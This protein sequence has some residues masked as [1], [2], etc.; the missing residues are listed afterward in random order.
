MPESGRVI[1]TNTT[2]LIA[3]AI[4]TGNLNI[5]R[6]L[7]DR[8]VV[9]RE[10]CDEL[11]AAGISAPGVDAF[12]KATWLE[13]REELIELPVY[14]RNTLDRGEAAVIQTATSERIEKVCIDETVGRRVARLHGLVLTGTVGVLIKAKQQGHSVDLLMALER[15]RSHGIWLSE[16]VIQFVLA[17]HDKSSI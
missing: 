9:P 6:S 2:P 10:V 8:V 15:M 1:V 7:Y 12:Q 16:Q 11:L 5:L 13:R 14:L 17:E 4:A 3:L